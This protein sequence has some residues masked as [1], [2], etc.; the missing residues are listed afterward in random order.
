[1][2]CLRRR[3]IERKVI[4]KDTKAGS[5][6][7][8]ESGR[9]LVGEA[10]KPALRERRVIGEISCQACQRP[11]A[12]QLE[13]RSTGRQSMFYNSMAW[14]GV[15]RCHNVTRRQE[16]REDK[17]HCS[18]RFRHAPCVCNARR[19]QEGRH[20]KQQP[21]CCHKTHVKL[22]VTMLAKMPGR[23]CRS[24]GSREGKCWKGCHGSHVGKSS[25]LQEP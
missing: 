25:M 11:A 8:V 5:G 4:E 20:V 21:R 1:M 15:S 13:L 22:S 19:N 10:S 24:A 23:C 14:K 18:E 9:S 3:H 7:R 6:K 17:R 12:H 16:A 2:L